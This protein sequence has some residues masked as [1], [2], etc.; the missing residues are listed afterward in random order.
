MKI[1]FTAFTLYLFLTFVLRDSIY[2]IYAFV[3]EASDYC[4]RG[5]T[6]QQRH[7]RQLRFKTDWTFAQALS[8]C[9]TSTLCLCKV[10]LGYSIVNLSFIIHTCGRWIRKPCR[11]LNVIT[12]VHHTTCT[13]FSFTFEKPANINVGI[14]PSF[15]VHNTHFMARLSVNQ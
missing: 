5:E 7:Y 1:K 6:V 14:T 11:P 15:L 4:I 3:H 10:S 9:F 2:V 12:R 8:F 13:H